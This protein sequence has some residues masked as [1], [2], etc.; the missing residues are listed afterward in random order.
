M[1]VNLNALIR[2]KTIDECLT[3]PYLEC[4]IEVLTT[5]CSEKLA[6]FQGLETGIS[7]RTT[8]ND[9]RILRSDALGFNAP[10]VINKGIYSYDNPDF[11]LFGRPIKEVEILEEIQE[12]LIEEFDNIQNKNVLNLLLALSNITNKAIPRKFY[13]SNNDL[14]YC[15]SYGIRKRTYMDEL[16]TYTYHLKRP[17]KESGFKH[18]FKKREAE[19]FSWKF[20]FEALNSSLDS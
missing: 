3:N 15:R 8:R 10:I 16:R 4:T 1:P 13:P 20:I 18:F 7:E 11:T 2:Y 12:L 6:E 19:V 5:K 9:I 14:I 17:I